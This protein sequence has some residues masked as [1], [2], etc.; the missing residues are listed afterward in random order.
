M[1]SRTNT[2][3]TPAT[4]IRLSAHEST[5]GQFFDRTIAA[6]APGAAQLIRNMNRMHDLVSGLGVVLRIVTGNAVL[7][8]NY[9]PGDPDS[10]APLSA[11]AEGMLT[12]MAATICEDIRDSI[13]A[14][15]ARFNIQVQA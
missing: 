11:T 2:P 14:R 7:T 3:V 6:S 5:Y 15:A 13:E 12:A 10:P 9:N 1:P 8:D 4:P